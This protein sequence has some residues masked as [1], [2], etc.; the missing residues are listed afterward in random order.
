V[1]DSGQGYGRCSIHP[2]PSREDRV[3]RALAETFAAR[4][5]IDE[6]VQ[7]LKQEQATLRRLTRLRRPN[8]L[9]GQTRARPPDHSDR[10]H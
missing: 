10:I 1:N 6:L 2:M 4:K 8:R 3:A 9:P 5:R 7:R